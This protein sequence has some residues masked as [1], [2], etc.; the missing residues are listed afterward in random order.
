M[1]GHV[2]L[3]ILERFQVPESDRKYMVTFYVNGLMAIVSEWLTNDCQDSIEH[4]CAI[5]EQCVMHG[6]KKQ[7]ET[8]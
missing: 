6:R 5:M 3:P 1:M 4:V 2:F 7:E 8:S